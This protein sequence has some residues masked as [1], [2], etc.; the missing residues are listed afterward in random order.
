MVVEAVV[1]DGDKGV[2]QVLRDLV[3]LDGHAVLRRVDRR[4]LV[5]VAVV[6]ERGCRRA[7]VVR[8]VGFRIHACGQ[9]TAA[10]AGQHDQEDNRNADESL[11][12][13]GVAAL[14]RT[15]LLLMASLRTF[16]HKGLL[17]TYTA[18]ILPHFR[19][20]AYA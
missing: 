13:G 16:F 14:L 4:D 11:V 15:A 2:L 12:L 3:E 9:E 17:Q 10:D 1:L 8:Q 7:D 19:G 6:D 20:K 5:A 18:P